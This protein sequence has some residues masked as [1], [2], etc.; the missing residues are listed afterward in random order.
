[1]AGTTTSFPGAPGPAGPAGPAGPEGPQGPEGPV[2]PEGPQGPQGIQGETGPQGAVGPQGPQGIQGETGPAGAQGP[3]G[4]QGPQGD[5]GPTGATGAQGP[6]GIQGVQ[7]EQGLTGAAGADGDRYQTTSSTELTLGNGTTTLT[8]ET[9]LDYSVTQSVTIA[10]DIDHHMHGEVVSY[11][12]G[13]GVLVVDVTN[14]SGSGTFSAWTV[15]L[16][17]AVG[18]TGPAGPEG[19]QGP[20]GIQG[21]QGIQG[22]QG[23]QGET[24]PQGDTGPTGPQ[25]IQGETGPAGAQGPTGPQGPQGDTGPAGP[26]GDS[27]FSESGGVISPVTPGN[28]LEVPGTFGVA[29]ISSTEPSG[30]ASRLSPGA[31]T[32]TDGYA[33]S[34]DIEAA[35]A[36]VA[37]KGDSGSAVVPTI[38]ARDFDDTATTLDLV[39]GGLTVNGAAGSSGQVLTSGGAGAA[40][41]WETPSGGGGTVVGLTDRYEELP[42]QTFSEFAHGG[43]VAA[44][45]T[46]DIQTAI[47]AT[48]VG[49]ACQV[50]VGPGSYA[51][52]TV[53][54]PTGRNNIS[55]IGPQAGDFGGTV[56]SL[57][58]GRGLTIGNNA[59]RVRVV[60]IQVEGLTTISTTGAGVHR[61]ERSQLVGG[62]TVGAISSYIYVVGCTL[63]NLVID[64]G[65]TGLVLLD[66]CQFDAGSTITNGTLPT[67]LLISDCAGLAAAPTTSAI[68]N[69]RFQIATGSSTYYADG[70]ALLKSALTAVNALTPA[71]DRLAYYTGAS[72]AALATLT[73][74]GRSLIDDVDAT[75]ARTTLGLGTAATS[76][77]TAFQS[78]DA[79]LTALAG[80][81]T[82]ADRLPYFT[83]V[84]TAAVATL[85][86]YARTLL[87]DA[88]AATARA[89]LGLTT[90]V[91]A[92]NVVVLDGSARLPA[93]DGSQVTGVVASPFT[94]DAWDFQ[95]SSSAGT[96]TTLANWT[97]SGAISAVT[98]V[99]AGAFGASAV[100]Y[101]GVSCWEF[102]PTSASGQ[103]ELTIQ[104]ATPV[105]E[106]ELR[107]RVWMPGEDATGSPMFIGALGKQVATTT[108][109]FLAGSS[110]TGACRQSGTA[111]EVKIETA[112]V[113]ASWVT[114]TIRATRIHSGATLTSVAQIV[115]SLYCGEFLVGSWNGSNVTAGSSAAGLIRFGRNPGTNTRVMRIASLQWR[116]GNNQATPAYTFRGRGFGG[117]GPA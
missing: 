41:T 40:P 3:E 27:M 23:I 114:M 96:P 92:G 101:E 32:I 83:G 80:L 60:S 7:G 50:I 52:A 14:H 59:V 107:A 103:Q 117:G 30:F 70:A 4:P 57:S 35:A 108:P 76:A 33:L 115:Y 98:V 110:I 48:P 31:A 19:P 77:S 73:A 39:V 112:D 88:D 20:Q 75:A 25:G 15:N 86:S 38:R 8:V 89:T 10:Y 51:G 71:A 53:T 22:I 105:D 37:I 13:T 28:T 85:T 18:A 65:F 67:R 62:L 82:A 81:T 55:I 79:T 61:I 43:L 34:I 58:S 42:S 109:Q 87:D 90:G 45:P 68:L 29:G 97:G 11:D 46:R 91:S 69:G 113:R 64:P 2:G 100:T 54:I 102:T 17:G 56:V 99:G 49:P 93:V 72:T 24:G 94:A 16:A 111:E 104:P 84:D 78:S 116:S 5:T 6:Q 36:R 1:M 66:R 63:G 12:D 44:S 9:G 95:W 74:F 21:E 26:A 106:W 47:D